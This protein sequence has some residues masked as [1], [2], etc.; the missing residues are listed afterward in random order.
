MMD[1]N[2]FQLM[3]DGVVLL[4]FARDLLVNDEDLNDAIQFKKVKKY[5]TD[6][7]NAKTAN[8]NRVIAIPHLGASTEEAEDNCAVMASHQL[9]DYI[10]NG[11]IKHSVNYPD[12]A[13]GEKLHK[14][15]V[16]ILHDANANILESYDM[17]MIGNISVAKN[18]NYGITVFD[19]DHEIQTEVI[20]RIPGVFRVR[21]L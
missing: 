3:K 20:C 16:I 5:V 18:A 9:M 21:T 4:N 2:A 12:L 11:N 19:S 6:F 1:K 8:M 7:P 13:L 10:D 15:R 14:H 17:Q